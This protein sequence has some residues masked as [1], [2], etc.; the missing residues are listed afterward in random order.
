ME[1]LLFTGPS[2]QLSFAATAAATT[3]AAVIAAAVSGATAY[4]GTALTAAAEL[5]FFLS[6][7]IMRNIWNECVRRSI[8][9]HRHKVN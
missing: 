3:T 9:G 5:M 8:A 4:V 1:W 6:V 7:M 2:C